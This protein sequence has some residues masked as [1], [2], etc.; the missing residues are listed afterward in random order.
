ML[1][2]GMSP[3]PRRWYSPEPKPG[4]RVTLKLPGLE[5]QE[6][7]I[8]FI[9]PKSLRLKQEDGTELVVSRDK[10]RRQ[11]NIPPSPARRIIRP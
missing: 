3:T 6:F 4:D 2:S 10:V 7:T 1:G 8:V 9:G 11:L 5:K